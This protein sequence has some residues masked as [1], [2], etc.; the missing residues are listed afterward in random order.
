VVSYN[1]DAESKHQGIWLWFEWIFCIM[2][3]Y[4]AFHKE[5]MI[6]LLLESYLGIVF[7][8][9]ELND[10]PKKSGFPQF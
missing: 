9:V 3:S 7:F 6:F 5:T 10:L 8:Y 2:E 4:C 1:F